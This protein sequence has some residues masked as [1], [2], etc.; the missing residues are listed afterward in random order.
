MYCDNLIM[1]LG[2]ALRGYMYVL[3]G[4]STG[5]PTTIQLR[6]GASFGNRVNPLEIPRQ[7]LCAHMMLLYLYI[8]WTGIFLFWESKYYITLEHV[9]PHNPMSLL[10]SS[11]YTVPVHVYNANKEGYHSHKLE[12]AVMVLMCAF[13]CYFIGFHTYPALLEDTHLPPR[14]S[15]YSKHFGVTATR[16]GFL[17]HAVVTGRILLLSWA[18]MGEARASLWVLCTKVG[19]WLF[20]TSPFPT[21]FMDLATYDEVKVWMEG[22][23]GGHKGVVFRTSESPWIK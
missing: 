2:F 18:V 6:A 14:A 7:C 9:H 16:G 13:Q 22:V 12:V 23:G 21:M 4:Y 17:W 8:F 3:F 1:Q 15:S 11:T 10:V 5:G 19:G 20:C